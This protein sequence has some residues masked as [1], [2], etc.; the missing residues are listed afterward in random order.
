VDD[1]PGHSIPAVYTD[2]LR[3]ATVALIQKVIHHNQWD[4]VSLAVLSARAVRLQQEQDLTP[5]EHFSLSL[6]FE[7]DKQHATAVKH[8]LCA[9]SGK[10]AHQSAILFSLAR[11]LRRMKDRERIQWLIERAENCVMDDSLSRQI[12]ILCEHDLRDYPLALKYAHLQMQKLEKFRAL[13]R[14]F[15]MQ[16]KEWDRRS[17]RLQ[18]KM[19]ADTLA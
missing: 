6:L 1:I 18:R 14:R 5:E 3:F 13:S 19:H 15:A 12:C 2:Y 9:L 17:R 11:N 16:W 7:K 4:I 8:Q 10:S